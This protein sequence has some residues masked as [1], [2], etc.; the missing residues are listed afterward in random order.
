M[1]RPSRSGTSQ[2]GCVQVWTQV[3]LEVRTCRT[4]E[5]FRPSHSSPTSRCESE[6]TSNAHD[7]RRDGLGT[8]P[9]LGERGVTT[10][11][12][13]SP[14]TCLQKVSV[15]NVDSS[16]SRVPTES[17]LL[18]EGYMS[19]NHDKI[20][21]GWVSKHPTLDTSLFPGT[22]GMEVLENV[23]TCSPG[24]HSKTWSGTFNTSTRNPWKSYSCS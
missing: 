21:H 10:K 18:G 19:R 5:R 16:G 20:L 6:A 7:Q 13:I 23:K 11:V 9:T 17:G 24:C 4:W 15:K 22:I 12:T 2:K 14:F 8:R 1:E 3:S